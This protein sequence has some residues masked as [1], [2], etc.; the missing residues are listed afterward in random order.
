MRTQSIPQ[1]TIG[2]VKRIVVKVGSNFTVAP[3][4]IIN[5]NNV[6]HLAHQVSS[7]KD[8]TQIILVVS[9]S[10]AMWRQ[11][12]GGCARQTNH[13]QY[14]E[15]AREGQPLLTGLYRSIFSVYG[16]RIA[17]ILI[18][19]E[20]YEDPR[21]KEKLQK[22]IEDLLNAGVVPII[23]RHDAVSL[24][25]GPKDNDTNAASLAICTGSD[26]LVIATDTELYTKDPR[27]HADARKISKV[28]LLTSEIF[29][30]AA[31]SGSNVG[32][33]GMG[34]K[35]IA[36]GMAAEKLIPTYITKISELNSSTFLKQIVSGD[37]SHA[38]F[39]PHTA[40]SQ[41]S[42]GF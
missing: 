37:F 28:K 6:H 3:D 29:A 42:L 24:E 39:I 36:A 34:T 35:L 40:H 12:Q 17:E 9:G 26:L 13:T 14:Q 38:T 7:L 4:W 19:P 10:V 27:T 22:I 15:F 8:Q 21:R 30:L 5:E 20:D 2:K 1:D 18:E 11:N 33:G 16:L 41:M 32:T 25:N 23:N 31:G